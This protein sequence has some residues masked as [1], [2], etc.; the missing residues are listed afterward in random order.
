MG[1]CLVIFFVVGWIIAVHLPFWL[2]LVIVIFL[3][4]FSFKQEGLVSIGYI[5]GMFTP[6]LAGVVISI[7]VYKVNFNEV[8]GFLN[9]LF[10]GV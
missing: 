2:T 1:V 5:L 9:Y 10:T 4:V 6:F 7:L 3:G 8:G